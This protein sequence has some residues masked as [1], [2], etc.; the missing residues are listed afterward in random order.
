M[1][2]LQGNCQGTS[3]SSTPAANPSSPVGVMVCNEDE[4][5]EASAVHSYYKVIGTLVREDVAMG[6]TSL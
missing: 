6:R 2:F 5:M 1:P 3:T 4:A